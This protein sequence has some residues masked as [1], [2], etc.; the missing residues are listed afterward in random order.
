[1]D[2]MEA[3]RLTKKADAFRVEDR[4]RGRPIQRWEDCVKRDLTGVR[5]EWRMRARDEGSGDGW[6][7]RQ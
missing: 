4:R 2:G 6:W 7:R 5:G 1:M 3:E